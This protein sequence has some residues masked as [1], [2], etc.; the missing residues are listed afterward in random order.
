MTENPR[1]CFIDEHGGAYKRNSLKKACEALPLLIFTVDS[2][3]ILSEKIRWQLN[4]FHDFIVHF[5]KITDIDLCLGE[6]I[7]LRSDGYI[8]DG[9]HRIIKAIILGINELPAKQFVIDPCPDFQITKL[10]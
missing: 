10:S 3:L 1:G 7:I 6:P 8:M 2:D 9:W 5:N 4:N